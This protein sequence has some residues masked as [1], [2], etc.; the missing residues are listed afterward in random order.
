MTPAQFVDKLNQNAGGVLSASER[1][2]VYN[3]FGNSANHQRC[4]R[5]R[6]GASTSSEDA[7]LQSASSNRAF[8]LSQFIG[9]LRSQS[10]R[11]A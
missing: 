9:Y 3:L 6:E 2:T 10:E 5:A 11:C 4:K 1:Q 8:V 7:D